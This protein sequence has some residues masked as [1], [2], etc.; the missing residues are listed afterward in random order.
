MDHWTARLATL[1]FSTKKYC[2]LK[3]SDL[4]F[5]LKQPHARPGGITLRHSGP[6]VPERASVPVINACDEYRMRV[7]LSQ[8]QH[9]C[10]TGRA[11]EVPWRGTRAVMLT[12]EHIEYLKT[13]RPPT[14]Q[15]YSH[16]HETDDNPRG[17]WMFR[18]LEGALCPA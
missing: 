6:P 4:H 12:A 9:W 11:L 17:V 15:R 18:K 1:V 3:S 5:S 8:A 13:T 10:A 16:C 7:P 2:M 14:G